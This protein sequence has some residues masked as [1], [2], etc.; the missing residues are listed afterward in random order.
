MEKYVNEIKTFVYGLFITLN[1][2]PYIAKC[3]IILIAI[4]MITGAIKAATIPQMTFKKSLLSIGL[5]KK[6]VL[7]IIVMVL[8]LV[9]KGLGI[10]D[11]QGAVTIVMK[12]MVLNE[13]L[14]IVYNCRSI[15]D[16]KEYKSND[17]ISMLLEKLGNL[18]ILTMEKLIKK[19]D[20][21]SSC[22]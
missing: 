11:F 7:L 16:M 17:F 9:A 10:T 15:Y 1:I 18:I 4:D 5:L 19:I 20:E 3:L 14:S 22:L 6:T 12:I 8:A 21:N 13:G 2:D